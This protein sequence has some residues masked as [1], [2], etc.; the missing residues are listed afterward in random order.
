MEEEKIV[1]GTTCLRVDNCAQKLDPL[2]PIFTPCF[3][4][5]QLQL[6]LPLPLTGGGGGLHCNFWFW[7][8]KCLHLLVCAGWIL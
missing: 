6:R 4:H 5:A 1:T 8:S 7:C 3:P 2:L